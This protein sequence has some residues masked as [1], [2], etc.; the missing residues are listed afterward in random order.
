M[1][2]PRIAGSLAPIEAIDV[3]RAARVHMSDIITV[4]RL[5]DKRGKSSTFVPSITRRL[6]RSGIAA[7]AVGDFDQP[8]A[9]LDRNP[10]D[11]ANVQLGAEIDRQ[12]FGPL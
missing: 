6:E 4:L 9:I 1:H 5:Y 3:L 2:R 10:V 8:F 7:P 12:L 11:A